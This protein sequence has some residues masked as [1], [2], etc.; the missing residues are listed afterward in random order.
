MLFPTIN[1]NFS[2]TQKITDDIKMNLQLT[3]LL[4]QSLFVAYS[5]LMHYGMCKL[6][7][8]HEKGSNMWDYFL[9]ISLGS[10]YESINK[11]PSYFLLSNIF[12]P[13]SM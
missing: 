12:V 13:M 7:M 4:I 9:R 6:R 3:T 11:S 8:S 5:L 10:L 2:I 1:I